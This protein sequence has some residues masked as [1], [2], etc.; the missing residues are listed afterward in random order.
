MTSP[1]S[2]PP[3]PGA[4]DPTDPQDRSDVIGGPSADAGKSACGASRTAGQRS[5]SHRR[6][7]SAAA[8]EERQNDV[9]VRSAQSSVI[10]TT[11]GCSSSGPSQAVTTVV[12]RSNDTGSPER[13]VLS[14]A[15]NRTSRTR[16]FTTD[17]HC[18]CDADRCHGRA[19]SERHRDERHPFE[20]ATAAGS[21]VPRRSARSALVLWRPESFR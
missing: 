9:S 8:Q 19:D 15:V 6:S 14:P 11:R 1:R 20:V 12:Q 17:H 3:H 13:I 16:K 4:P 10:L 18:S 5:S 2:G 21:R 7:R